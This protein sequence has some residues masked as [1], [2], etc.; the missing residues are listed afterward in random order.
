MARVSGHGQ[1]GPRAHRGGFAAVSEA[2][3]GLRYINGYPNQP[4]PRAG[5]S[6][7]DSRA[8]LFALNGILT[9]LYWRDARGG[10]GQ[11]ADDPRY[12]THR[13]RARD[14]GARRRVRVRPGA[15][16]DHRA[17]L[18]GDDDQQR[19]LER[20]PHLP[21]RDLPHLHARDGDRLGLL[22]EPG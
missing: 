19:L 22:A 3:G 10:E 2:I 4:P 11:L 13:D 21:G 17:R 7:G 14:G 18:R 6:L 1:T 9:A 12:R 8:A 15:V 20:V 16:A 5:I